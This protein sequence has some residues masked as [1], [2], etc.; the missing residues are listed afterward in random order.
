MIM[1]DEKIVI[2]IVGKKRSGKD[3]AGNYLEREYSVAP[4]QKLAA[5]IKQIARML[6]GWS[7]DMVEGDGYDREQ[8][9]DE[10]GL[11]VR[12]FLQ[13]CGS[14]FKYNLSEILPE[15]GEKVGAKIWAKI[16][17]RWLQEHGSF[18]NCVTDVRF[19]E[20][21]EELRANFTTYVVKLVSDRSPQDTHIS[22]T[23]VDRIEADFTIVNNG[24][25]SYPVLYRGLDDAMHMIVHG[26]QARTG[27]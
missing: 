17:V 21:V 24:Y 2:A 19:P 15:Y 16:L 26:M 25:D 14:L 4:A 11:S 8:H 18:F 12:Q 23:S 10:L 7:Q 13:E 9:I 27:G 20:E 22:E 5:P 1:A 3:T 6:F